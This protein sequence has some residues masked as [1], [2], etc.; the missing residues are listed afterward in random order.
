M[1][2]TRIVVAAFLAAFAVWLFQPTVPTYLRESRA[3]SHAV[4]NEVSVVEKFCTVALRRSDG[5]M[6]PDGSFHT[7]SECQSQRD[8]LS[9]YQGDAERIPREYVGIAIRKSAILI[10]VAVVLWFSLPLID[11]AVKW[12]HGYKP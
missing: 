5:H 3:A 6:G 10:A 8:A 7:D 12:R 11:S 9:N 4:A 2:R 1:S